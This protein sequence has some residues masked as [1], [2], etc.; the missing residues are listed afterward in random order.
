MNNVQLIGRLTRDVDM[1]Y[2][3]GENQLAVG[4]FTIAVDR[5]KKQD[6]THETDFID[7]TAF[8][9]KAEVISQYFYK[10]SKIGVVGRI[11]IGSYINKDNQKVKTF[12]IEVTDIDFID[13]KEAQQPNPTTPE[14]NM[15]QGQQYYQ[16][17]SPA[18]ASNASSSGAGSRPTRTGST[19]RRSSAQ[20]SRQARPTQ[21]VPPQVAAEGGY[22]NIPDGVDDE[23]L[24][25]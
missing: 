4:R 17:P 10:G 9:K 22:M 18:S 14:Y 5:P 13:P 3:Q 24:P 1:R 23:G 12:E 20:P 7:C 21:Q 11:R 6:G 25:F 2:T 16:Q 19:Q 15:Q 8:G